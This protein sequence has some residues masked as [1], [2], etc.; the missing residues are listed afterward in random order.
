VDPRSGQLVHFLES[1]PKRG[2]G[3]VRET[4]AEKPRLA[5]NHCWRVDSAICLVVCNPT[6]ASVARHGGEQRGRTATKDSD[7]GS[8]REAR[9][10]KQK[11]VDARNVHGAIAA[12]A[13]LDHLGDSLSAEVPDHRVWRGSVRASE[14]TL[15]RG[16]IDRESVRTT[17]NSDVMDGD[18]SVACGVDLIENVIGV[19]GEVD[20]SIV[21]VEPG[22]FETSAEAINLRDHGVCQCI[23]REEE[24]VVSVRDVYLFVNRIEVDEIGVSSTTCVEF[25]GDGMTVG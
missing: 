4:E 12:S 21:G 15:I 3:H 17:G 18:E 20:H 8:L 1:A 2:V 19:A 22:L 5:R 16:R 25:V 10:R 24:A 14:Q 23:D 9:R 13:A 7:H 6:R 11:T